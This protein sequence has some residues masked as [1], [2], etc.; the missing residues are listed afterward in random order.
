MKKHSVKKLALHSETLRLLANS[1][2]K[3]EKLRE[4][5]GGAWPETTVKP[6]PCQPWCQPV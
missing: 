4:V 3:A 5:L 1:S 2:L 6:Y